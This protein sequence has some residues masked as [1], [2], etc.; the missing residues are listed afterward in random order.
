MKGK[1]RLILI[2]LVILAAGIAAVFF[3]RYRS[4]RKEQTADTVEATGPTLPVVYM[5]VDGTDVNEMFGIRGEIPASFERESV[6]PLATDKKLSI[7]VN[8]EDSEIEGASY[9]LTSIADESLVENGEITDLEQGTDGTMT[10]SFSIRS[11]LRS[12]QEYMLR[13][14]L[15][16]KSGEDVYYYTRLVQG[17][18]IDFGG[19]L[20]FVQNFVSMCLDKNNQDELSDYLETESTGSDSS[21]TDIDITSSTDMVTWGSLA[22][23]MVQEM[24]P[25][26]CACNTTTVSI[27]QTSIV[28]A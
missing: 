25:V 23:E 21:F 10:A 16:L 18:G 6:T 5:Q 13:I 1:V 9:E 28:S 17:S 12:D 26:I 2:L 3:F 11:N 24:A 7:K 14:D 27:E 22:P 20:T 8:P 15:R 4:S 19:Y